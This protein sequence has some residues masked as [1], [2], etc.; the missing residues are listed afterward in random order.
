MYS[1]ARIENW[2][3]EAHGRPLGL[4]NEM[5]GETVLMDAEI[6]PNRSLSN[7][8]FL[9]LM[10]AVI[11]ISFTAGI[12]FASIGAWPV[13]GFFGLDVLIIWLA[14]RL[15]YRA[16]RKRERV[17]ITPERIDVIRRWPTG[18]ETL[19]RLPTAWT[20]VELSET[21]RGGVQARL[22]AMG[23]CLIIG[24][25]LSPRERKDLAE[26]VSHALEKAKSARTSF[27]QETGGAP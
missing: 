9:A 26:V 25:M 27:A 7:P 6:R 1:D 20:R 14:F 19:Y 16:G 10:G 8:A 13:L 17:H 18:H 4:P 11:A 2:P 24:A 5:A 22:A 3:V 15:N 21:R 23:K 12:A